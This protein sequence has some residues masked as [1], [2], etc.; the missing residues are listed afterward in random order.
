MNTR[1]QNFAKISFATLALAGS[2]FVASAPAR[3]D[4]A[5][6]TTITTLLL[7]N[8]KLYSSLGWQY[9]AVTHTTNQILAIKVSNE[10]NFAA[11]ATKT[12]VI[13]EAGDPFSPIGT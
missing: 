3:A 11:P 10:G 6:A 7:P 5:T 8:L 12:A 4:R 1:L 13:I 9:N 2:F